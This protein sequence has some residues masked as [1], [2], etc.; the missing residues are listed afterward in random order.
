MHFVP[1]KKSKEDG[2][3]RAVAGKELHLL[4]IYLIFPAFSFA[5]LTIVFPSTPSLGLTT[6][7]QPAAAVL[8]LVSHINCCALLFRCPRT[9]QKPGSTSLPLQDRISKMLKLQWR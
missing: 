4:S 7:L 3:F 6:L 2:R 1:N 9:Q 5:R 8:T